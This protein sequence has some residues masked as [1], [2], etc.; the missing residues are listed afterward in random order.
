M[1][2]SPVLV[3]GCVSNSESD[4][5]H[6]ENVGH[7]A[8]LNIKVDSYYLTFNDDMTYIE[9]DQVIPNKPIHTVL[10]FAPVDLLLTDKTTA[11]DTSKSKCEG[12]ISPEFLAFEMM[13]QKKKLIFRLRYSGISGV[14][15]IS[16]ISIS[17]NQIR[18]VGHTRRY[19]LWRKFLYLLFLVRERVWMAVYVWPMA[20]WSQK[21]VNRE[22]AEANAKKPQAKNA[23]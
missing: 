10:K 3:L 14:E 18:V 11:L 6:I 2:A 4:N 23:K 12:L 7:G 1:S 19:N 9:G 13:N 15:Y 16:K 20:R 17:R 8:A 5:I 22:I 21:K